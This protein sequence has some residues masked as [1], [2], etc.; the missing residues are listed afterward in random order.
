M[1][2]KMKYTLFALYVAAWLAL[3]LHRSGMEPY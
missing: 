2:D 1:S 3:V